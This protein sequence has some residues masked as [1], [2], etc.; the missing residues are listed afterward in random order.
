[1]PLTDH[2]IWLFKEGSHFDLY[3]KLGAHLDFH[4][5]SFSVWAPNALSVSV[6]GEFNSWDPEKNF[7]KK[8]EDGSGIWEGFIGSVFR[9]AKYKYHIVS[10]EGLYRIDKGDPFAFFWEQPPGNASIAWDC[11]FSWEESSWTD[12]RHHRNSLHAPISI[13]ECHL[14][15]WRRVPEENNRLLTYS[16][17]G[18][19]LP[20]YLK[21]MGF[22]HVEFLPVMEH[23]LYSSWGYQSLG[24]FA[25]SSR[26]GS[27]Q[28]FMALIQALHRAGIGVILDWV[29]SHFPSDAYGLAYYDGTHLY[30]YG[31]HHKRMHPDWHTYVFDYGRP[32]VR[33]FLI[34]NALFWF[35]KYRIDAI[36]V[37]AVA[38]MLYLD[39]SRQNGEWSPNLYGGKENLEAI[40]FLRRLNREVY[41]RHPYAQMVAEESTDWGMVSRPTYVGGLGFGLK[42]NMGWMHDTLKY[43]SIDPVFRKYHHNSLLFSINYAFSENYILSLSH[44]EVVHGKRSLLNKMPGDHWQ[45]FANLR[46]LFGYMFGHP[47]KKLIFMGDEFGQLSEWYH[48]RS[49]DWH[50]LNFPLHRQLQ[51]WVRDLNHFYKTEPALH[52]LDFTPQG[53]EWIDTHDWEQSIL[54]FMRKSQNPRETLLILCNFTPVP[55]HHYRVGVPTS[56]YWK[57][58][59]NSDAV[60]YGGSGLGNCGGRDTEAVE[61]HGRPYSMVLTLPPLSTLFFKQSSY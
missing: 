21:E 53:F 24:Y 39:Y 51:Q 42:W 16:E 23:P 19:T 55:R 43:M 13:Y 33:S 28:E 49:L 47:G 18:S 46:L 36:R 54:I 35:D 15:S 32:E 57:E 41:A 17:L 22:T 44:D 7:L 48:E 14:P 34:S 60:D 12:Q 2:D 37:D 50:L 30:E 4:G 40:D 38:S 1:M 26:Y 5:C 45:K 6:I 52:T 27:P 8:R 25:P 3:N 20:S 31:D 9:G 58:M 61:A 56:G 59:L 10:H 29:P 11:N